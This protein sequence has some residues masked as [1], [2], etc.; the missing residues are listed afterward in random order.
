MPTIVLLSLLIGILAFSVFKYLPHLL[1]KLV[2]VSTVLVAAALVI[3]WPPA[4][5]PLLL[6]GVGA[7]WILCL[8]MKGIRI[9][10]HGQ[11]ARST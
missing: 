7:T 6:F 4:D 8:A 9:Y 1:T 5:D 11:R 3:K 10:Q 2:V